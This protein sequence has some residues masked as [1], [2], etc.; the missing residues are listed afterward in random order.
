MIDHIVQPSIKIF[1]WNPWQNCVMFGSSDLN[2][3]KKQRLG[4]KLIFSS[5]LD[6]LS[7][8]PEE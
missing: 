2:E 7:D 4:K 8:F 6:F 3:W 1:K 5:L